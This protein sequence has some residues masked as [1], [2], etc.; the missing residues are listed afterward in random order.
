MQVSVLLLNP[1]CGHYLVFQDDKKEEN[2]KKKAVSEKIT[3]KFLE[4]KKPKELKLT[5]SGK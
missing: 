3:Q 1:I 5:S 4:T 2:I